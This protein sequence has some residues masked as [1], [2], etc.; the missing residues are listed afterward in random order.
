MIVNSH[1][2]I[3]GS[4]GRNT[5][6]TEFACR[7]I[8]NLSARNRIIGIKIIP[9]DQNEVKCHRGDEGCG[10]CDSLTGA[11]EILE[12]STT[13]SPKDT[14]RM[15]KAGAEKVYLLIVNRHDLEKGM[16]AVLQIVPDNAFVVIESNT[17]R[18]VIEPGLF[19]VIKKK[20]NQAVKESCAEV[21][22]FA[23]QIIEFDNMNWDFDPDRVMI[24][25]KSW[26]IS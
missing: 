22:S 9:V 2:L 10:L 3:I 12:E 14:A 24:Q 15:L 23:D 13:D 6:K 17:I 20:T 11:Y 8:E 5:G 16:K 21:I 19:I 1:I 4:T 25:D 7:V 26:K 18:K